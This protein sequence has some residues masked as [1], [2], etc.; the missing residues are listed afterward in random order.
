MKTKTLKDII[1]KILIKA[2]LMI[3]I[4]ACPLYAGNINVITDSDSSIIK[5]NKKVVGKGIL[6]DYHLDKGTYYVEVIENDVVLYSNLERISNL[7]KTINVTSLQKP[8]VVNKLKDSR[9]KAAHIFSQKSNFGLGVHFDYSGANSGLNMSYKFLGLEHQ[10]VGFAYETD[11]YKINN[12][13]YRLIKYFPGQLKNHTYFRPYTGIGYG[14]SNIS[15]DIY[16]TKRTLSEAIIGI[17]FGF[18]E[19]NKTFKITP[20]DA[21]IGLICPPLFI[22][23]KATYFL[24]NDDNLLYHIETGYTHRQTSTNDEDAWGTYKGLKLSVGATYKF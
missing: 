3:L 7:E 14:K 10:I 15:E 2:V 6:T 1:Q 4:P 13:T 11:D 5:I 21:A 22:L 9:S 17:Q 18:L 19:N 8:L 12:V 23:K 16:V 24:G 20:L